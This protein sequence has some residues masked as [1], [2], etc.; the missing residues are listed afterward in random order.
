MRVCR[1]VCEG[2]GE[3]GGARRVSDE[4]ESVVGGKFGFRG[5]L[6]CYRT[7]ESAVCPCNENA[8]FGVRGSH[9]L[10]R[11]CSVVGVFLSSKYLRIFEEFMIKERES[12]GL[13]LLY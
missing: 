1:V 5:G 7:A 4:V 2:R 6:L 11:F 10:A 9:Y 13:V 12:I 8:P 3:S